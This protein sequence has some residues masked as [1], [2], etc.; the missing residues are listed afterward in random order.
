[1]THLAHAKK[2]WNTYLESLFYVES[3][4]VV[5]I[6]TI[7]W[8]IKSKLRFNQNDKKIAPIIIKLPS[9]PRLF[10]I[11]SVTQRGGSIFPKYDRDVATSRK[12][13]VNSVYGI[14]KSAKTPLTALNHE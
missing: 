5:K 7:N 11:S 4:G 2:V 6:C 1:M 9:L 12:Y 3:N 10:Q 8:R 14:S 13:K